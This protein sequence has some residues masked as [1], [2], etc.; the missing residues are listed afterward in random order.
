M[1]DGRDVEVPGAGYTARLLYNKPA[2][3]LKWLEQCGVRKLGDFMVQ[4]TCSSWKTHTCM[5]A[6]SMPT[7]HSAHCTCWLRSA[8]DKRSRR[9]LC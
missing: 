3:T 4:V 1:A 2:E 6:S 7:M 9:T 8:E 5:K